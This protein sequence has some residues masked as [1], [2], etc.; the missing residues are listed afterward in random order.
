[1][2]K[3]KKRKSKKKQFWGLTK[4]ERQQIASSW[5]S[6]YEGD[7]IVKSYSKRFRLNLKN[8]MKELTSFGFT[9][10]KEERAKMKRLTDIQKY[11]KEN[12]QRK[13]GELELKELIESD[14]T[15]AFIAG[16]TEG[17]APFGITQEEMPEIEKEKD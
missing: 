8:S 3:K 14:E 11:K 1:M 2:A 13:K 17:G 15:F 6:E 12:K 5:V 9:I 16:Y 7:N 10:S 4:E